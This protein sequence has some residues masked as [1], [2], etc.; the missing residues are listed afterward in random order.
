MKRNRAFQLES[1]A[2]DSATIRR[3][4][5]G[6]SAVSKCGYAAPQPTELRLVLGFG[7]GSAYLGDL[8]AGGA[9]YANVGS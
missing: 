4:T 5:V 9:G 6:S 2:L 8:R 7:V 1:P 3:M